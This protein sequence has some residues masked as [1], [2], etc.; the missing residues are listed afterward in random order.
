MKKKNILFILA[1]SLLGLTA[2]GEAENSAIGGVSPA[3]ANAGN[4][5]TAVVQEQSAAGDES[6]GNN[7]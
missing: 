4:A 2:C 1:I 7:H 3:V 6:L 5:T